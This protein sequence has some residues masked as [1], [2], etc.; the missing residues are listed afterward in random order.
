MMVEGAV[1]AGLGG[2]S[3]RGKLL[4]RLKRLQDE[5]ASAEGALGRDRAL[6]GQDLVARMLALVDAPMPDIG[7]DGRPPTMRDPKNRTAGEI[8]AG[9]AGLTNANTDEL[10][11]LASTYID[12]NDDSCETLTWLRSRK[13]VRQE[14]LIDDLQLRAGRRLYQDW[15]LSQLC[16]SGSAFEIRVTAGGAHNREPDVALDAKTKVIK[17]MKA[18]G[19]ESERVL[20]AVVIDELDLESASV[21]GRWNRRALVSLVRAALDALIEHYARYDKEIGREAA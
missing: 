10:E 9:A 18:V 14:P 5:F 1:M 12:P 7:H 2:L 20:K 4:E 3:L 13:N 8:K 17:A 16:A 19:R 6:A 11:R 15:K 21:A